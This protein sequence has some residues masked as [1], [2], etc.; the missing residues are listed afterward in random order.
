M[1][2]T[3]L[4]KIKNHT[5]CSDGWKKLLASLGKT[6]PDDEPL[7]LLHILKSNGVNDCLW[8]FRCTEGNDRIYGHM[9]ADFAESVLHIFENRY[10]KDKRPRLAIQAV[11]DFAD[12]KID[13]AAWTAMDAN[14][15]SVAAGAAAMAAA[16][17]A[18]GAAA[19]AAGAAA[20][21]DAERQKQYDIILK[22]LTA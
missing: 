9:A 3:T 12:G 13:A 5:P 11:R 1:I 19:R 15:W 4:N 16:A 20:A 2:T 14:A 10:P 8:A 6:G 17:D 21:R 7:N 22:Y 18:A